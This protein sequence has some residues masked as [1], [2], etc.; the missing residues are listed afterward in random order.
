MTCE[1]CIKLEAENRRLNAML[2]LSFDMDQADHLKAALGV[3]LQEAR[4]IATL[5]DFKGRAVSGW[6]ILNS[7]EDY[8]TTPRSSEKI[9]NVLVFRIRAKLGRDFIENV[10]GIGY[11]LSAT[12]RAR[13]DAV[14]NQVQ[15]V[16]A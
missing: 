1:H 8:Y 12:A 14:I 6:R 4:I 7:L 2:G 11:A 3:T 13:C 10:W 16:A 15:Q 9:I 5:Y